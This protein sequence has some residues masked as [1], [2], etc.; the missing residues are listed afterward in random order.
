MNKIEAMLA[1]RQLPELLRFADGRAVTKE[2]F[3]ARRLEMVDIL[4]REVYGYAP[5]AP[6]RVTATVLKCKEKEF[7]GKGRVRELSLSFP[8]DRGEFAFPVT[9]ILPTGAGA[10]AR[11]PVFVFINF[12][13][14]VPDRY[15]PTEEILDAGC[16]V[17]RIY[18]NDVAFDGED[19]FAGGIAAMYD[20]TRY[21]WG[22]LRMW[23][24]AMSRVMDYLQTVDY[25]DLSRVAAVGHS[26]LGKTALLAAATDTR[27]AMACANCSGC[28]GDAL[29]RG[30]AG[31]RVKQI[32]DR[33]PYWFCENYGKYAEKEAQMPFDQH[34]LLAAI[35]PRRV[36]LGTAVEDIWADPASQ[37]L[38]ACAASPAWTLFDQKGFAHPDRLPVPGDCLDGGMLAYHLR[39]GTHFLSRA[40]WHRY[41]CL[42]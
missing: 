30:K 12:R 5:P 21:S 41:L 18:Y 20:R 34:F 1:E 38:S 35:A 24:F 32:Y 25:A 23:A 28:A 3:E 19:H 14:E 8:T 4:C 7:A 13:P 2:N 6:D 11:C 17:V 42:L 26:R 9:E 29:T 15:F 16:G 31:E 39:E 10:D 33:F 36:A 22:K 27:F 37:Y 40:D